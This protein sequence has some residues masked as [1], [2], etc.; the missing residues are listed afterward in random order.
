ME[1]YN[2][3]KERKQK[4]KEKEE[5][6]SLFDVNVNNFDFGDILKLME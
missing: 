1:F 5:G 4:G 6:G 2:E 3:K